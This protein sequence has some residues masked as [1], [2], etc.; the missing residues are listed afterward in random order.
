MFR[1]RQDAGNQLAEALIRFRHANAIVLALPRGGVPVASVVAKRLE[2]PIDVLVCR[3]LGVP[4]QE[5]FAFGAIAEGDVLFINQDTVRM[6]GL[7]QNQIDKIR[8]TE[9]KRL[10]QRVSLFRGSR[11]ISKLE[12]KIALIID[13]GLATGATARAACLAAK[14]LG[15]LRVVL[16]VPVGPNDVETLVPEA[17]E[18]VCLKT[19]AQFMAVGNHYQHFDQVSDEEVQRILD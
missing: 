16:A 10:N 3:K 4:N 12:G 14:M 13:D 11:P 6:V 17:D 2:L 1:D 18:I 5:E 15:A 9:S 19:P 8:S 7:T